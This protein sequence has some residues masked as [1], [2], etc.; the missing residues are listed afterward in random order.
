MAQFVAN[1]FLERN[2]KN[3]L[4]IYTD[5]SVLDDG[6]AGAAFVVPRVQQCDPLVL[7]TSR[8]GLHG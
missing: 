5:G 1:E 8:V 6:T 4:E 3:F 2:Y 7:S